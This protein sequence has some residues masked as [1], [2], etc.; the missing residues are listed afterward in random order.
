[1]EKESINNADNIIVKIRQLL[2]NYD[3]TIAYVKGE[4]DLRESVIEILQKENEEG[5]SKPKQKKIISN[6][7]E[8]EV[9]QI[10]LNDVLK[11][12]ENLIDSLNIIFKRFKHT[13]IVSKIFFDYFIKEKTINEIKEEMPYLTEEVIE[14]NIEKLKEQIIYFYD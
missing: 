12:R 2:L 4:I 14:Q 8:I 13:D 1:M 5:K 9:Y 11:K 10:F 7:A 3:M 6:R